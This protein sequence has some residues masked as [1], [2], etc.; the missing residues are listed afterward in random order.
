MK[1]RAIAYGF[2]ALALAICGF[3]FYNVS[4]VLD[5]IVMTI[6][7]YG[8]ISIVV[9]RELKQLL[10]VLMVSLLAIILSN[11]S[12]HLFQQ[13]ISFGVTF[14]SMLVLI[15]HFLIR[16]H[17]SGWFGTLCAAI[18]SLVFSAIIGIILAAILFFL[19]PEQSL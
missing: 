1:T 8:A 9:G 7:L 17:E 6:A 13:F 4:F 15:K 12:F 16:N 3:I 18:L 2:G 11:L 19:F 5:A 14:L 10:N